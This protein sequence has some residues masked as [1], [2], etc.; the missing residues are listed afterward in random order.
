VPVGRSGGVAYLWVVIPDMETRRLGKTDMH[1]SVL[2]FGGSE[3]GYEEATPTTVKRLL[4]AALD[5]GLNVIDTAECYLRSEELIGQAVADRRRDV[6]LFTKC[7]HPGGWGREDWRG[8]AILKSVERSLDRLRTDYVDLIQLHSCSE[9]VLR[10]GDVIDALERARQSGHARYIGYSGDGAAARYAVECG[11]FDTLQTS[12]SIADQEALDL[13]L[14]L[15]RMREM[16]VIAKRPIANAAWK[17]GRKPGSAYA[18]PY[19]ERLKK[20]DYD[21][22][23]GGLQESIGTALR[24][25]LSIPGVHTA[26]VGTARPERWRENAASLT[27]GPLPRETFEQIRRRWKEVAGARWTGEV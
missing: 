23:G 12:I 7:G 4:A 21:F 6:H 18:H 1:V 27:A 20:L 10:N 22:L 3:I 2:G 24:F 5:G 26:I 15:A 13:T 19:W 25:T 14:P 8:A 11:R 16:G 17:T 9:A